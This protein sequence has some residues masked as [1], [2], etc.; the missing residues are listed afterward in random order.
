MRLVIEGRLGLG[1]LIRAKGCVAELQFLPFR[2]PHDPHV[3]TVHCGHS[4]FTAVPE[5]IVSSISKNKPIFRKT[6]AR[7][8]MAKLIKI[9]FIKS[10]TNPKM[11]LSNK[12]E[13]AP[14]KIN[15][16]NTGGCASLRK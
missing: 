5:K 1:L 8:N 2:R 10:V 4:S 14:A 7:L 11:Y 15:M 13:N 6:S 16:R 12:L 3:P 9:G